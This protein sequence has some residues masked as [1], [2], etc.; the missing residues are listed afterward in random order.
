VVNRSTRKKQPKKERVLSYFEPTGWTRSQRGDQNPRIGNIKGNQE[1]SERQ[2]KS[3]ET[4]QGQEG[5][6]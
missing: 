2:G 6:K 3:N 4:G 1:T 5:G